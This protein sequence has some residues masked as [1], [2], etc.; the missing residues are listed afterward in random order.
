MSE[1]NTHIVRRCV[2]ITA[3]L[4]SVSCRTTKAKQNEGSLLGG[5]HSQMSALMST[6]RWQELE[7]DK[8]MNCS[9]HTSVACRGLERLE[10]S[11]QDSDV[12]HVRRHQEWSLAHCPSIPRR[13]SKGTEAL[14]YFEEVP[15][16]KSHSQS[17]NYTANTKI[18]LR[19]R[20]GTQLL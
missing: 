11:A 9:C 18:K 15:R 7:H 3:S 6:I 13:W 8:E 19:H 16:K 4:E 10:H 2:D 12:W 1:A 17:S 5:G 14:R 20:T